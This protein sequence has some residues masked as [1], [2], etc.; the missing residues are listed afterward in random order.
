MIDREALITQS[1]GI[2]PVTIDG[3]GEVGMRRIGAADLIRIRNLEY[4]DDQTDADRL[5]TM[6]IFLSC[7]LCD[8]RG[9][10]LF[11]GD[12]VRMIERIPYVALEKL[13]HAAQVH[14]G[15]DTETREERQKNSESGQT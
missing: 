15:I 10:L 1:C 9:E 14:N 12:E 5:K 6:A 8:A 3:I 2:L 11:T 4:G 7:V 13:V